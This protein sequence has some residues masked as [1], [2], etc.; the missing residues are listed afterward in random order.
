MVDEGE[1]F[2]TSFRRIRCNCAQA[3]ALNWKIHAFSTPF[4]YWALRTT[5]RLCHWSGHWSVD[6]QIGRTFKVRWGPWDNAW[7]STS[8]CISLL[9]LESAIAIDLLYGDWKS[10]SARMLERKRKWWYVQ[11]NAFFSILRVMLKKRV[12]FRREWSNHE[13]P[14]AIEKNCRSPQGNCITSFVCISYKLRY[15]LA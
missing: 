8:R 10:N 4:Y 9:Q 15:G 5:L 14:E 13:I 1:L 6:L 7:R 3:V 11:S 12:R 2:R